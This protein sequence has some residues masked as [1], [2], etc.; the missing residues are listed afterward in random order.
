MNFLHPSPNS[1]RKSSPA[2]PIS[3]PHSPMVPNP[4]YE[5]D[6]ASEERQQRS[7]TKTQR[8]R[9]FDRAYSRSKE[10]LAEPGK[11]VFLSSSLK[12]PRQRK[13][14]SVQEQ[15]TLQ[16]SMISDGVQPAIRDRC[17]PASQMPDPEIIV[18]LTQ[19]S[20]PVSPGGSDEGLT[21]TYRL[22]RGSRSVQKNNLT[23]RRQTRQSSA[24]SRVVRTLD[25]GSISPP[26]QRRGRRSRS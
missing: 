26:R 11:M 12:G 5:I 21:K 25:E 3:E 24:S 19:S 17:P 1:N 18:D 14:R 7:L 9:S 20:P 23:T 6:K 16:I 13:A 4:S 22:S 8:G 15:E 10:R 2:E